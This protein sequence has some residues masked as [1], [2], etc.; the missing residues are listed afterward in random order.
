MHDE[1]DVDLLVLVD[2]VTPEDRDRIQA[3]AYDINCMLHPWIADYERYH[4]P[5]NRATGFYEEVRKES[6]RL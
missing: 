2:G 5:M 4:R 3:L 1:S 6:I